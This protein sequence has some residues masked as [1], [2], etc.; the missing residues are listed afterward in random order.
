MNNLIQIIKYITVF[1]FFSNSLIVNAQNRPAWTFNTPPAENST[2]IYRVE[3]G[4]GDNLVKAYNQALT[5]IINSTANSIGVNTSTGA[6]KEA[7]ESGL[8]FDV[9]SETL[10]I[11]FNKV[12]EFEEN[13]G[14][15]LYRVFVLCQTAKSA[16]LKP[17]FV[18]FNNCY[19][20]D[21]M[22]G[23]NLESEE[24]KAERQRQA[25]LKQQEERRKAE[26]KKK[27]E[28]RK[29]AYP[30]VF[31]DRQFLFNLTKVTRNA[32]VMEVHGLVQNQG[33]SIEG[34]DFSLKG[35]HAHVPK[36]YTDQGDVLIASEIQIGN[37]IASGKY[38]P[39]MDIP[40]GVTLRF[41]YTFN[42]VSETFDALSALV[43]TI[44]VEGYNEKTHSFKNLPV[45]DE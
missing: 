43:L 44:E 27:E 35:W 7:L 38:G 23:T 26:E 4:A 3:W 42:N 33:S 45:T 34:L 22:A 8:S 2:F 12:C 16:N 41:K 14:G 37:K 13:L 6:V 11:P 25:S 17:Q 32:G 21:E 18:E 24:Q 31:K 30:K 40:P 9:V 28:A 20:K 15:G 29:K 19:E 36:A 5:K 39:S 10:K 1:L